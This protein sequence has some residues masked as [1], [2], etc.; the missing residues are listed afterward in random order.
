MNSCGL[1]PV[2][3]QEYFCL[4]LQGFLRSI[5]FISMFLNDRDAHVEFIWQPELL[6]FFGD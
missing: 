2:E 4:F 1:D 6:S 3:L 5:D